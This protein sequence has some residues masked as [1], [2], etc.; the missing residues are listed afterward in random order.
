MSPAEATDKRTRLIDTAVELVHEQ[1]FNRTSLADLAEASGVP[2]GNIYY[3][4]KT[5]DALGEAL[6]AKIDAMQGAA[7]EAWGGLK[8]PTQRLFAMVDATIQTRESVAKLG[9]PVGTLA[10]ELSKQG[11]VLA[12]HS[13]RL[14]NASVKFA[15]TQFR[16]LGH[17]TGEAR[18]L[19]VHLLTVLQGASVMGHAFH[20]PRLIA[21]ECERLKDWI[22]SV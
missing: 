18:E 16:E 22:R 1:G 7:F 6:V 4:F 20:N 15:E 9:C 17:S 5:K 19:A 12:E 11:G 3:Y 21:R 2:L 8:S 13:A 10:S 14:L